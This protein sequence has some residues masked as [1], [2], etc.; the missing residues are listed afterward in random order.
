ME[1]FWTD[2]DGWPRTLFANS[3]NVSVSCSRPQDKDINKTVWRDTLKKVT[4]MFGQLQK[5]GVPGYIVV[6]CVL[7]EFTL[8]KEQ[9]GINS[10]AYVQDNSD[11]PVYTWP[12]KSLGEFIQDSS[13]N[14]FSHLP[15]GNH[16]WQSI[17]VYHGNFGPVGNVKFE[18]INALF[19]GKHD[20]IQ[21][22]FVLLKAYVFEQGNDAILQKMPLVEV[23]P[24]Q[25]YKAYDKEYYLENAA[26]GSYDWIISDPTVSVRGDIIAELPNHFEFTKGETRNRYVIMVLDEP[27]KTFNQVGSFL[28]SDP[29]LIAAG[30][31]IKK[32]F[33]K[34]GSGNAFKII[35]EVLA[36]HNFSDI[37]LNIKN[38][39]IDSN[40]IAFKHLSNG[41]CH[42]LEYKNG[43]NGI[44][45]REAHVLG[46]E[47]ILTSKDGVDKGLL[48]TTSDL[49]QPI[50]NFHDNIWRLKPGAY[51]ELIDWLR[52]YKSLKEDI[53]F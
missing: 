42:I 2:S 41:T 28:S 11:E 49:T 33:M 20:N 19:V 15:F 32:E 16:A 46:T 35:A 40:I 6:S 21:Q 53:Y 36:S 51:N 30:N 14:D 39:L 27:L 48:V 31:Q 10:I 3:K 18:P 34:N 45:L 25:T 23:F 24:D 22:W 9:N 4:N 52:T 7:S 13:Q 17:D 12:E 38:Q 50:R 43:E 8:V 47:N 5:S 29:D 1:S 37:H 44:S 26:G